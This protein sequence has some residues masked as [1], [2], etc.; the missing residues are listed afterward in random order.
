MGNAMRSLDRGISSC[1]LYVANQLIH[2]PATAGY[3]STM[4]GV[5]S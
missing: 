5:R 4:L 2:A 3:A 1:A